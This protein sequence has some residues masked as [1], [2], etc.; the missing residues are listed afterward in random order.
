MDDLINAIQST[1]EA[2]QWLTGAIDAYE[3]FLDSRDG[4][5]TGIHGGEIKNAITVLKLIQSQLRRLKREQKIIPVWVKE[6]ND[7][8]DS[9][10]EV[11]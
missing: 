11:E 6:W 8:C 7:M 10:P 2:Y 4:V 3:L 1:D 5:D 9:F